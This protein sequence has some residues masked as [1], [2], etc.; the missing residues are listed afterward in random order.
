MFNSYQQSYM[1][2]LSNLPALAKCWCGWYLLGECPNCATYAPGKTC[3]DKMAVWCLECHNDPGPNSGTI[4]HIKGCKQNTELSD[5]RGAGSLEQLV[6]PS[7]SQT[8]PS[9]RKTTQIKVVEK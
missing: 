1:D 5:R 8:V 7:E 9:D 3:A 2:M 6:G 4:T